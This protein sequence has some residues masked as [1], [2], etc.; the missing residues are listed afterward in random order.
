KYVSVTLEQQDL[1]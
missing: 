1:P